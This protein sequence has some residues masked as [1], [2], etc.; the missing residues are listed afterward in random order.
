MRCKTYQQR[1][2]DFLRG[3]GSPE[4]RE[5]W[6]QHLRECQTCRDEWVTLSS[7]WSDLG[8]LNTDQPS[9]GFRERVHLALQTEGARILSESRKV[10]P[11]RRHLWLLAAASLL[12]LIA[13]F[14]AG[15]LASQSHTPP[16]LSEDLDVSSRKASMAMLQQESSGARIT[17]V[18][19]LSQGGRRDP[20]TAEALLN[21]VEQ[22]P[23][24]HVRLAALEALYL[25]GDR[26]TVVDRLVKSLPRQSAP[27]VQAAQADLLLA[28][29]EKRALEALRQLLN[30]P[31]LNPDLR[32]RIQSGLGQIP[33]I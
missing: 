27:E 18:A 20:D 12:L 13:G 10:S 31:A 21:L 5:A 28:L 6:D 29:R 14:A 19:L 2:P 24:P 26:P 25:F 32:R 16:W 1:I 3:D 30:D 7:L 22:D 15:R 4:D 9:P 23:S 17:G 11:L 8:L 33:S